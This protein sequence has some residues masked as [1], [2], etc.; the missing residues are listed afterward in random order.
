MFVKKGVILNRINSKYL[1]EK[2]QGFSSLCKKLYNLFKKVNKPKL[3]VALL[4]SSELV[5]SKHCVKA[6][7]FSERKDE[8]K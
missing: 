8:F 4:Y 5:F 6:Q 1:P 3:T 7:M 2:E